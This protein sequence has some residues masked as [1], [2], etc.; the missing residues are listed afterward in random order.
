[1]ALVR[2]FVDPLVFES[3]HDYD[4]FWQ[5]C[6]DLKVAVTV[7]AGCSSW[8][9]RESFD[10]FSYGHIGHFAG[11]N[12]NFA[13]GLVFGGVLKRFPMLRFGMLE[14]GAGWACNLLTD[15]IAHWEKRNKSALER[16]LRPSNLEIDKL[17]D[18]YA[19]YGGKIY[20]EKMDQL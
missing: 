14:G 4:R 17:K 11:A 18:L 2:Q 20:Q 9:G 12:H 15:L 16:N 3:A 10:N 6:A 7:H 1:P 8:P 19:R 13:K 5:T